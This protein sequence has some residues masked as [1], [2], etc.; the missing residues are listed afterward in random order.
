MSSSKLSTGTDDLLGVSCENLPH[1]VESW[2][3]VGTGSSSR[4]GGTPVSITQHL[5]VED[6]LRLLREAQ[7]STQSSARDSLAGSRRT[8]PRSSPKSPPNSPVVQG[9]SLNLE[10]QTY[11]M[12]SEMTSESRETSEDFDLMTDWSSRPDQLPPKSWSFRSGRTRDMLSIRHARVGKNSIFSKK[13]L[14][15]LF[16]TNIISVILGTGIGLWLSR[17][18]FSSVPRLIEL[19]L[20]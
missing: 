20:R 7:E 16:L 1:F 14:C 18:G 8:S 12:N 3:E 9:S 10:W 11:Y 19:K 4:D 15:T 5:I 17:H 6:Y 13:G 2:V